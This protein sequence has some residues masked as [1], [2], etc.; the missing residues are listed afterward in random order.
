M[1]QWQ[2]E[3]IFPVHTV[4]WASE[5]QEAQDSCASRGLAGVIAPKVAMEVFAHLVVLSRKC[6][7]SVNMR[8]VPV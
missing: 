3:Y 7:L 6:L 1:P 5:Q 8:M 4:L 2:A